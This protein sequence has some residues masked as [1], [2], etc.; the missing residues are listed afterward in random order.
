MFYNVYLGRMAEV[1]CNAGL[2]KCRFYD[3]K[4]MIMNLCPKSRN[5]GRNSSANAGV[6]A[7]DFVRRP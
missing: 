5:Q 3:L 4:P 7:R 1:G 2:E 6:P